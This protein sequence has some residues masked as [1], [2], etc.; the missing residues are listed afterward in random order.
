M[1]HLRKGRANK[2]MAHD[3]PCYELAPMDVEILRK[4]ALFE[5]M[6]S[7]Q[8]RKLA[9]ALKEAKFPGSAHIFKEGDRK[10]VV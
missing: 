4:V 5:G 8:L 9:A 2:V 1:V 10:S 3:F 7:A 6:T